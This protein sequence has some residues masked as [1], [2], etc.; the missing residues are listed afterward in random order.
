[1]ILVCA[2][3]AKSIRNVAENKFVAGFLILVAKIKGI[4]CYHD[5]RK[6]LGG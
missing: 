6:L 2:A 5:Q 3:A 1:M 4:S